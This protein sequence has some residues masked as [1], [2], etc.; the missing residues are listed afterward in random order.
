M[1][2]AADFLRF[3]GLSFLTLCVALVLLR[4]FYRVIGSDLGLHGPGKEFIVAVLASLVEGTGIWFARSIAPGGGLRSLIVP[5]II[6]SFI[7]YLA[8]LEKD[9]SGYEAGGI[10]SF[11]AVLWSVGFFM[12][13]GEP[14]TAGVI[15]ALFVTALAII[16]GI[17][18]SGQQDGIG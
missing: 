4:L 10:L 6:V 11:Q 3:W 8:H 7:Y 12:L 13:T 1:L 17:A 5:A 2:P 15:S 18:K 16:G 9:W 14:N